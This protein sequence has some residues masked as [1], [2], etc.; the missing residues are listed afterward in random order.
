MAI[1]VTYGLFSKKG[2]IANKHITIKDDY[3]KIDKVSVLL[4]TITID[5][6]M[7]E[8]KFSR[9]FLRDSQGK[10]AIY[11]VLND[12]VIDYFLEK[13][14]QQVTIL[15]ETYHKHE[16]PYISVKANDNNLYYD[17]ESGKYTIKK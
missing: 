2:K 6:F 8:G 17:L 3:F 9:Y 13:K 14:P 16:G 12:D 5:C 10:I 7:I 11:S 15:E 4:D 1:S